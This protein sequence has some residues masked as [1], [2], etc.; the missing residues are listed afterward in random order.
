MKI[1]AGLILGAGLLTPFSDFSISNNMFFQK[2]T[3][4]QQEETSEE[5]SEEKQ[6]EER[7]SEAQQAAEE[8]GEDNR[9]EEEKLEDF[10]QQW[11]QFGQDN[12][13]S[14]SG[15]TESSSWS[16]LPSIGIQ[17]PE[18][19]NTNSEAA[20]E[21]EEE[22]SFNETWNDFGREFDNTYEQTE[23][24]FD[25]ESSFDSRLGTYQITEQTSKPE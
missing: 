2:D 18:S 24:S 8:A 7:W 6:W 13:S 22:P 15:G 23:D 25:W 3:K 11:N 4:E 5:A 12:T 17:G 1:A 10:D 21:S 20:E 19:E 16:G 14:S 9:S